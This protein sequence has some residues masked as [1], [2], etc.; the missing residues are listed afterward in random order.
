MSSSNSLKKPL[1][2]H[3][4]W[5][6]ARAPGR[7][8]SGENGEEGFKNTGGAGTHTLQAHHIMGI[9]RVILALLNRPRAVPAMV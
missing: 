8:P 5:G 7:L 1:Q 4:E 9:T 2:S 3:C 6:L